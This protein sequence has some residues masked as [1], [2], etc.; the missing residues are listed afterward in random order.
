MTGIR[1]GMIHQG[2]AQGNA[3]IRSHCD[4]RIGDASGVISEAPKGGKCP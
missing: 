3:V 4:T 2:G 1:G